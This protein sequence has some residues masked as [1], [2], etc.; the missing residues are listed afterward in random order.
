MAPSGLYARLCHAF[1]VFLMF[2]NGLHVSTSNKEDDDDEN[3]TGRRDLLRL[4]TMQLQCH[5]MVQVILP[6]VRRQRANLAGPEPVS[7]R[8]P[9]F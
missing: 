1:L 6:V 4:T 5:V 3:I 2:C 7:K 9:S 8:G